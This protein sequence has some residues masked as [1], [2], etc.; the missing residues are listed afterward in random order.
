MGSVLV[1]GGLVAEL[2]ALGWLGKLIPPFV[3]GSGI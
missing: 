2:I 3:G 1:L